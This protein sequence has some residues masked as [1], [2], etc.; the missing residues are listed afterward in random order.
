MNNKQIA[1]N[2]LQ[3]S[4]ETYPE[5]QDLALYR[6]QVAQVHATL[7]LEEAIRNTIQD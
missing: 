7:A 5:H 3:M 1:E 2:F 4:K 6:L